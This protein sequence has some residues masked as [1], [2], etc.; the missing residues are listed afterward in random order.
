M[1]SDGYVS[2]QKS[3]AK[4]AHEVG[5]RDEARR[6]ITDAL[7]NGSIGSRGSAP[8]EVATIEL[9]AL[10]SIGEGSYG[11][12]GPTEEIPPRFWGPL[13]VEDADRWDWFAGYFCSL[14][15]EGPHPAYV[16]VS[17]KEKDINAVIKRHRANLPG[18]ASTAIRKERLRPAKWDDWVA[19]LA[20]LAHEHSIE[21]HMTRNDLLTRVTARL[22]T[23]G[24]E[25]VPVS[26]VGRTARVVLERFRTD[27]PT[28]PLTAQSLE[29]P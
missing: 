3:L 9:P 13:T 17:F 16:D 25:E 10:T 29:K 2:S 15:Y 8:G 4:V 18:T 27:P 1:A 23:W 6:L 24:L 11:A 21:P 22:G 19:A 20:T 7:I 26:T 5:S 14:S 12:P 28:A